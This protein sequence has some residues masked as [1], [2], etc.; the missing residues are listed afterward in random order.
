MTLAGIWHGANYTFLLWGFLWG[1]YIFIYRIFLCKIFKSNFI[2]WLINFI[3]LLIL[4]VIFRSENITVAFN[5]IYKLLDFD[6]NFNLV[7]ISASK[8]PLN[9]LLSFLSIIL[10]LTSYLLPQDLKFKSHYKSITFNSIIIFLILILG[11]NEKSEFIYFQ[12]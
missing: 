5:I 7:Q 1:L 10:L 6:L 8:G 3:I 2:M 12:F 4:W 11:V 9:L